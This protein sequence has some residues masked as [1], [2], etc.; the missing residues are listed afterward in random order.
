MSGVPVHP[1]PDPEKV[2]VLPSPTVLMIASL[3]SR[4]AENAVP[5]GKVQ[6]KVTTVA[7][8]CGKRNGKPVDT[9]V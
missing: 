6:E 7:G 8:I 1:A 4:M 9:A 5:F 3:A 2:P